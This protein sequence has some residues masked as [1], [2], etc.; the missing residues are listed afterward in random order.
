MQAKCE[1]GPFLLRDMTRAS[2]DFATRHTIMRQQDAEEEEEREREDDA[3]PTWDL[4]VWDPAVRH[5]I[6]ELH[7]LVS[8]LRYLISG[9]SG[10]ARQLDDFRLAINCN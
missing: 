8:D 1:E 10:D 4:A 9:E 7:T 6:P 2:T 3:D 5:T